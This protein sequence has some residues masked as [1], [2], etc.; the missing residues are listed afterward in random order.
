MTCGRQA[1]TRTLCGP[2]ESLTVT[3]RGR[4]C[5]EVASVSEPALRRSTG[6]VAATLGD[7]PYANRNGVYRSLV[8][9][10]EGNELTAELRLQ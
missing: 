10:K 2:G 1:E 9:E 4:N 5:G 6:S 7:E 8:L 3:G